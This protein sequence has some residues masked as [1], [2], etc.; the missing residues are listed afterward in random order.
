MGCVTG[1]IAG[2]IGWW[3]VVRRN[4]AK[5]G[6]ELFG[7]RSEVSRWNVARAEAERGKAAES[8]EWKFVRGVTPLR[9]ALRCA[10]NER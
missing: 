9:A 6:A 8:V 3:R 4:E 1:G 10:H 5:L 2:V 7:T